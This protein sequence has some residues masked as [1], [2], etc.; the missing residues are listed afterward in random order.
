ML[1]SNEQPL[2]I[3]YQKCDMG[4]SLSDIDQYEWTINVTTI[5]YLTIENL[6]INQENVCEK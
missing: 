4:L 3:L 1:S 5:A 6:Y 2:S